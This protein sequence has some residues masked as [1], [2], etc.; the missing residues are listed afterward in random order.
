MGAG[1]EKKT[2]PKEEPTEES[3]HAATPIA[4][5]PA[6]AESANTEDLYASILKT[7]TEQSESWKKRNLFERQWATRDFKKNTG[8]SIDEMT[9]AL[10]AWEKTSKTKPPPKAQSKPSNNS[11]HTMNTNRSSSKASKK[12][13]KNSKKTSPQST[14]G[15]TQS[16]HCWIA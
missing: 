7:Y 14:P 15:S 2:E 3:I 9:G 4:A 5:T 13:H 11:W 10:Q 16:R 6:T 12:T 1:T 8:M